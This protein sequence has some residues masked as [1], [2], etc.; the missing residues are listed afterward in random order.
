MCDICD[1]A[2]REELNAEAQMRIA[3]HGYTLQA[4]AGGDI[5]PWVYTIG[6]V[7]GFDHPEL[8]IVGKS[9]RWSARVLA[10][11]ADEIVAGERYDEGD[12]M[13]I[14]D[15]TLRFGAVHEVQYRLDTFARWHDLALAGVITPRELTALQ[16]VLG[17]GFFCAD[18]RDAQ[19]LL[20]DA[21]ARVGSPRRVPNRA[22]RRRRRKR[23]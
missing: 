20:S 5:Q 14:D 1:G 13:A 18:C 23:P 15:L 4:V 22:E 7:D 21:E 3:V 16:I 12:Q 17:D 2:T 10:S 8:I 6:L 11:F 9:P 19:T